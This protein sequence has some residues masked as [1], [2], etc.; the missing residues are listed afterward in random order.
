MTNAKSWDTGDNRNR[1]YGRRWRKQRQLFLTSH[2]LCV[3]CESEGKVRASNVVD[4]IVPHRG[5]ELLFW[6]QS[7]WQALCQSH[8]NADKAVIEARGY[9][10]RI[11]AD[12]WPVDPLHPCNGGAQDHKNKPSRKPIP[13]IRKDLVIDRDETREPNPIDEPFVI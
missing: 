12:G 3:M 8:H 11:G 7:N 5:D 10:D 4:H 9:S 6:D 1:L 2:P 13:Q